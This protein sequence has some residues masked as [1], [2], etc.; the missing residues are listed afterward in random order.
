MLC[1]FFKNFC[2]SILQVTFRFGLSFTKKLHAS[3]LHMWIVS[4]LIGGVTFKVHSVFKRVYLESRDCQT[5]TKQSER[6]LIIKL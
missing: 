2:L 3:V 6:K 1:C 5:E 4:N